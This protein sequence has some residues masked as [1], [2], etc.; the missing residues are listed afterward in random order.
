[1]KA[2]PWKKVLHI[3]IVLLV[4]AITGT[5]ATIFPRWV[6]PD[7]LERGTVWYWVVYIL[8]ITPIYQILLLG[9]AFLFGKFSYFWNKQKRLFL[10]LIGRSK[11]SASRSSDLGPK[12]VTDAVSSD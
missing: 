9:Y 3:V 5:T 6:I 4:F 7:S 1:M 8:L 10:W 11:A 12:T 2:D